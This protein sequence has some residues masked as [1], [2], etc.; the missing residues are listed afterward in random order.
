M[1]ISSD[2]NKYYDFEALFFE[3]KCDVD[4]IITS[5]FTKYSQDIKGDIEYITYKIKQLIDEDRQ[6]LMRINGNGK[7]PLN[8]VG[9]ISYIKH[10]VIPEQNNGKEYYVYCIHSF[11]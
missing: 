8:R 3:K 9:K 10:Y 6:C 7:D 11:I 1:P 5:F 2:D 4:S